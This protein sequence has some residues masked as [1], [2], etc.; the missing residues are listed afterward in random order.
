MKAVRRIFQALSSGI[1]VS[2]GLGLCAQQSVYCQSSAYEVDGRPATEQE[3]QA[4][5]LIT[6]G[7]TL[8]RQNQNAAA[9]DI[10]AR[11]VQL[12]PSLATAHVDYAIALSKLN[13][14]DLAIAELK[15]AVQLDPNQP[16]AWLNLGGLYQ[17]QGQIEQAV[18]ALTQF[19]MRFPGNPDAPKVRSLI[20]G[21]NKLDA[22]LP[23]GSSSPGVGSQALTN[24]AGAAS[25]DNVHGS[26]ADYFIE[27][28]PQGI[29]RWPASTMPIRVY[30]KP[31]SGVPFYKEQYN[32]ILK[33][34]FIDW[35]NLSNGEVQFSFVNDRRQANIE[36][37]W[38]AKPGQ[39][40][41]AAEAG[42][43]R[44]SLSSKGIVHATI[45]LLTVPLVASLPITDNRLR[46]TCLHEIGHAL[47]LTGHTR[48]P[49]DI[50][51]FSARIPDD[52]HDLSERDKNTLLRLYSE[53]LQ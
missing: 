18:A 36:C 50:M 33:R 27:A 2:F 14:T 15:Q 26:P 6:Q 7:L 39:L 21:L 23:P 19:T 22:S 20:Q 35:G 17:T 28:T 45:T 12:G 31:G 37:S 32:E 30:L 51:F 38:I 29:H 34:A 11:A 41:N 4:S 1:I 42:E 24:V 8:L 48:N 43:T 49:D 53:A 44:L 13:K 52:W 10:F 46:V 47:G 25:I 3:F 5:Q 16:S 9:A 40:A